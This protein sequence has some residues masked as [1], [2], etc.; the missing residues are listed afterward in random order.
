MTRA[1][2]D[3]VYLMVIGF[4]AF[5][6]VGLSAQYTRPPNLLADFKGVYICSRCL[7]EHCDPYQVDQLEA[8]FMR[9]GGAKA[10]DPG[11]IR[12][13]F[14]R[15]VYPPSMFLFVF[16]F[17]LLSWIPASLAWVAVAA[18]VFSLSG[19]LIWNQGSKHAPIITG[20]M[21][22]L[23]FGTSAVI[24]GNGNPAGF[25]VG[26]C[27][28]AVWC[29]LTEKYVPAGI[30]CLAI[31]LAIKPQDSG[32][33]WL[34]FLLA[35]GV[36]RKRA[37]QTLA[38][39]L[40]F[41][42]TGAVW[43]SL[44][45][46]HWLKEWHANLSV[47]SAHGGINDPVTA[48]LSGG[49]VSPIIGLQSA[50]AVFSQNPSIYNPLTYLLTGALLL[51]WALATLRSRP[52]QTGA[53]LALAVIAPLTMLVTYHR[54]Y[55]AKLLLLTIPACAMLWQKGGWTG[56]L[57]F[58]VNTLGIFLT[59]EFSG[60]NLV[61]FARH[62]HISATGLAGKLEAV[63]LTRPFPVVLLIMTCFYLWVYVRRAPDL[64][65]MEKASGPL[66][67]PTAASPA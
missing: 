50:L 25:V 39:V 61:A 46:P 48:G 30:V 49:M 31:S 32:F 26:L 3:G 7:L 66:D 45:S 5:L 56:R 37:L 1:R 21:I 13:G 27:A 59:G 4:T 29:F 10:A 47:I 41:A 40:L 22:G 52:S 63:V 54:L 20:G 28:L 16:P 17:A 60:G 57:A 33:V 62:L 12:G 23:W 58:W 8:V 44:I 14:A 42:F 24:F 6:L 9:E 36:Y 35:G 55:D 11:V 65:A 53:W 19:F 18:L 51:I 67:R 43:V 2:M 38:L 64:A 34:Y 15:C